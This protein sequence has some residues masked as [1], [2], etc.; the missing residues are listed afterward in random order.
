MSCA[1]SVPTLL[2]VTPSIGDPLM[3]VTGDDVLVRIL[4]EFRAPGGDSN[5]QF[6]Y[7][8]AI[9]GNLAC[10]AS[11]QGETDS[12]GSGWIHLLPLDRHDTSGQTILRAPDRKW[13]DRFGSAMCLEQPRLLVGAPMDAEHGWDAGAAWLFEVVDTGWKLA[14]RLQPDDAEEGASFGAAVD[15]DGDLAVIGSPRAD[16]VGLDCGSAQLFTKMRDDWV[17]GSVLT[18]P[19][20]ASSD[21]FGSSVACH[22]QWIAVGAWGDDD[23]GE[24]TGSVWLFTRDRDSW[25]AVQKIVPPDA[26]SR[27]RFGWQVDFVAGQLLVSAC[28]VEDSKGRIYVHDFN[29]ETWVQTTHLEDPQGHSGDWF[30]FSMSAKGDLLV[31][32]SPGATTQSKWSGR[33]SVY[34]G[35]GTN[36]HR[37]GAVSSASDLGGQP[38]QFGWTVATDGKRMMVGRIDDAD[39]PAVAGRAWLL[40]V[41]LPS[42]DQGHLADAVG[43]EANPVRDP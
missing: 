15:L 9:D 23:H 17:A 14:A 20:Q 19:D 36:W 34:R 1:L 29:G 42:D 26:L 32:G 13:P 11:D 33:A 4:R 7:S 21:F 40:G 3:A 18:A 6:G 12:L 35:D 41:P 31:V 5:R 10:V 38:V 8:V 30:G 25:S 39:G 22:D 27:D 43:T 16:G 28:G 37:L 24:K 2:T